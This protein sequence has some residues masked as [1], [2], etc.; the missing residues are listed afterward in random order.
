M[1]AIFTHN[2]CVSVRLFHMHRTNSKGFTL[3]ELMVT[4]GI[5]AILA[6]LAA[7]SIR[8]FLMRQRM[9]GIANDF[10]A[11]VLRAR[12]QASSRNVCTTMCM[13][14]NP[15]GTSPTCE[16]SGS[17]WQQGWIAFFNADCNGSISGP[18]QASDIFLI[19]ESVGNDYLLQTQ[20]S[21]RKITFNALGN[22]SVNGT[23]EFDII[24]KDTSTNETKKYGLNICLDALG[25]TRIIPG[26]NSCS[27]Y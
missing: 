14:S 17:D 8:D 3:V 24:Y 16:S 4:I 6:G 19:H 27:N 22:N 1:I 9:T 10:N 21:K 25:R 12:N 11:S 13:S 2:R 23:S 5:A 15:G 7:P 26:E 20:S 18:K